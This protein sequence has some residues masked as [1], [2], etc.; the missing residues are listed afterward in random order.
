LESGSGVI[1]L[2]TAVG[3]VAFLLGMDHFYRTQE[4]RAEIA[5]AQTEEET[6]PQ[7]YI[8]IAEEGDEP[9]LAA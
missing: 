8:E 3:S 2:L 1:V 6:R 4:H 5:L 9:H 7:P